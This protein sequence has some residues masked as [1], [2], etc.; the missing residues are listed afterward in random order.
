LRIRIARGF[1][2]SKLGISL[3]G[4]AV[5]LFIASTAVFAYYC[6]E[7][8]RM[9]D[10]RL[11]GQVFASTSRVYAAPRRL[12]VG[13][14][15]SP[16]ELTAS[17]E[18]AGYQEKDVPGAPGRFSV[19]GSGV[20]IR[21]SSQSF[22]GG[23][24]SIRVE[25]SGNSIV[26]IVSLRDNSQLSSAEIEPEL[27]TN[28]F[29]SLR[30][31]R[32]VVR[33]QDLP[34][35]LVDAV[36]SAEDKRFFEHP[37]LDPIRVLG[38][39]WADLRHNKVSQG[40]STLDMQVARSFFFSTERTW[41][42]KLA[43]T[44]VALELEQRFTKQQIFELYANE[45]YLGNRGSFA[46][47]GFGEAAQAYFGKDVHDLK[48]AE[49]AFLAGIIR[50][51]NRYAAADRK[52]E[53][54]AE[55]R[56][57]VLTAM[58]ENKLIT[59]EANAT[60]RREPLRL[61][62]GGLDTSSAPY[63]VD[64]VKDHLLE[65]LSEADLTAQSYRIYTTVDP[66]LERAAVEA[67]EAGM[68]EVD[69]QLKPRYD[70][71]RREN[72]CAKKN[73]PVPQAQVALV[74][75]DPR[76]GEIRALVGG[77]DYGQSQLNR[78]LSRRQPGSAFKPF[79]FAAAFDNAI[80]GLTPVVTPLTV[81]KDEPTTFLFD[82]KEYTPNNYGEKFYGDVTLRDALTH[83][84]N[85][86]T[87]RVAEMVGYQHVV[88]VA[89]QMGLDPRIQATP[90]V[91]LG[92][93]EMSPLEVA[94]G[95][96]VFANLGTRAE[97]EFMRGVLDTEG[98]W[99]ERAQPRTRPVLDPR[100]AY[101]VS[102]IME[103]VVNRGTGATVRARGFRA[104]A[105]GKTGTSRDGWF[106]GYT[107]NLLC[108]VWVGFDDNRELGLT[109][110]ASAAPVWAEFMKRAVALPDYSGVHALAAPEGVSVVVIDPET[111][112]RATP[113]CPVTRA[114]VYLLGSEPAEYCER[115]GGARAAELAAASQSSLPVGETTGAAGAEGSSAGKGNPPRRNAGPPGN[116]ASDAAAAGAAPV[117]K[118][119]FW[120][121]VFGIFGGSK[122]KP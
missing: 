68:K 117:K 18:R 110:G 97:P 2:T 65:H 45:I 118:K 77:R 83:S 22:F 80:E 12:L 114:E 72:E 100:V 115:H 79:V 56:D 6:V 48:L 34:K 91:A 85:V 64:M 67:V 29:D 63:F 81:V 9:I 113:L 73:E 58:L 105:A 4:T 49:A 108:V 47:R 111:L 112:Q 89:R 8:S 86:A 17:L 76:T 104:P 99:L 27:L 19:A 107:S 106:A 98:E 38:A 31:K 95:Y 23:S 39:A 44:L 101:E 75:L 25:F 51:P 119:G 46:I 26:G 50:A 10:A 7:Y 87:V 55:A 5:L 62:R 96:T 69:A 21:P 120:E 122:K 116:P 32:R 61:F 52:P 43:E 71:W 121:K 11:S 94:G 37:G 66:R 59:P 82:G 20:S 103:D 24:N 42:R 60:A 28:L 74:A 36:L 78:A 53:R 14:S 57:R 109:G 54:G 70:R 93:Y 30:E 33:M 88:D 40:A 15:F 1:W 13:E 92:A 90:A 35:V 3:L 102:N 16:G 41:R 84:L